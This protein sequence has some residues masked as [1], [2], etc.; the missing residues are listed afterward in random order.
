MT[1][2]EQL[3]AEAKRQNPDKMTISDRLMELA[4]YRPLIWLWQARA[5]WLLYTRWNAPKGHEARASVY[6][7][8]LYART[9]SDMLDDG[10]MFPS[11][12]IDEDRQYWDE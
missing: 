9:L 6:Q 5:A 8:W 1:R 7:Q 10:P 2:I 12:A 4:K 3:I 11:D